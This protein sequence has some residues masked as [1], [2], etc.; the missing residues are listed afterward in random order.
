MT[1]L[2]RTLEPEV[3]DAADVAEAYETMDHSAPSAAI[4]GRLAELRAGGWMLDLG[5]G[6]G[7]ITLAVCEQFAASRVMGVDMSWQM[8]N[9]AERRRRASSCGGRVRWV[10]ADIK[11]LP[12]A[13]ESLDTVYSNT[14][15]HHLSDPVSMLAEACRVLKS[16]GVLLIRDLY[17]PPSIE[18]RDELVAMYAPPAENSPLQRQLLSDSLAAALTPQELVAAAQAAGLHSARVT[19]DTDRHMTLEGGSRR[20]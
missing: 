18:R 12:F 3:M 13:D 6:P 15:L 19:V 5:C 10:A 8:L 9:M 7:Q 2:L 4:I 14:T 1:K 11:R 16:G 20:R 17:R